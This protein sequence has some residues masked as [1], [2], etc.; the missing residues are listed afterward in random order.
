MLLKDSEILTIN[1]KSTT[2][3]EYKIPITDE[4]ELKLLLNIANNI[5]QIAKISNQTKQ[6][7]SVEVL[8]NIQNKIGNY[9][10]NKIQ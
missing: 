6:A 7:P 4:K 5:N 1:N 8:I 3:E 9:L 2:S 10:D